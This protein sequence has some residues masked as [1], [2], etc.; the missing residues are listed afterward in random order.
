MSEGF[1]WGV[2]FCAFTFCCFWLPRF[3]T[4]HVAFVRYLY[5]TPICQQYVD[6][7]ILIFLLLLYVS[8][9]CALYAACTSWAFANSVHNMAFF[10]FFLTFFLVPKESR[11]Y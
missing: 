2:W 1:G 4:V 7:A 10:F 6:R 11:L 8:Q 5:S 3:V 9:L